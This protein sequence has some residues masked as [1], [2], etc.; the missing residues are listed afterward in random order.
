[1]L[2]FKVDSFWKGMQAIFFAFLNFAPLTGGITDE[3]D[4]ITFKPRD[5]IVI[6]SSSWDGPARFNK[7]LNTVFD[8]YIK[9][10]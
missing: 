6:G 4:T 9:Y 8:G 1:M 5:I 10:M 7:Y 2:L 3:D